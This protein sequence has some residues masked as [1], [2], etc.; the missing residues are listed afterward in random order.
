MRAGVMQGS[1]DDMLLQKQR[2]DV[3]CE[4]TQ[5]ICGN[6]TLNKLHERYSRIL[7]A[8]RTIADSSS[9]IGTSCNSKIIGQDLK[10]V[11][12]DSY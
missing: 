11:C 9:N 8:A 4:T 6:E 7:M 1:K 3:L 5:D 2:L 10:D 12:D